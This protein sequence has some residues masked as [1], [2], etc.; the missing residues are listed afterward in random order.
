MIEQK[1]G[2]LQRVGL[3]IAITVAAWSAH[4]YLREGLHLPPGHL[5]RLLATGVL[6][7]SFTWAVWENIRLSRQLDEFHRQVQY[8]ALAI[9]YPLS[10]VS[11]F[12]LG[13]F[14]AEGLFTGADP[15][16]LPSLILLS[17][18][19]GYFIGWIRYR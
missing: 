11:T 17:G 10:L 18:G 16:D 9:A 1:Q 19:I 8:L 12:A 15:R 14:R 13:F 7:L 6:V 3:A 2:Q 5:L 4:I